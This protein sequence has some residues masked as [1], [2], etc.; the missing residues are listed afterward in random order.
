MP[1]ERCKRNEI[2][3]VGFEELP[4]KAVTQQVGVN[5]DARDR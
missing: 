1:H 4:S 5:L 2:V 3:L